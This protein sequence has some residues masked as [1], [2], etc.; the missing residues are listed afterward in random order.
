MP[1]TLGH[2]GV[3]G[4]ATRCLYKDAHLGWVYVGCVLPDFPW[5]VQR[6]VMATGVI[7]RSCG[8]G[9]RQIQA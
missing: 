1:N 3:Q 8:S 5:I 7:V 9:G 4:F 6:L 2:L